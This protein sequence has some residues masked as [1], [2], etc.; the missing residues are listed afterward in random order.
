MRTAVAPRARTFYSCYTTE[1]S[2]VSY[3]SLFRIFAFT[4]E[5]S[6]LLL[7]HLVHVVLEERMGP[8]LPRGVRGLGVAVSKGSVFADDPDEEKYQDKDQDKDQ[9]QD[10][11]KYQDQDQDKDQ[12]QD[13]EK[14]Q[15]QHQD[16]DQD[17]DQEKIKK[18]IKKKSRNRSRQRS[19]QRSRKKSLEKKTQNSRTPRTH[20]HTHLE[21]PSGRGD[22][23]SSTA[24]H[25]WWR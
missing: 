16:K 11:E 21:K 8:D 1:P 3:H 25:H 12:D 24:D 14:Y 13:E 4:T 5:E 23:T 7:S 2:P 22:S 19:R 17:K 15:D 20:T 18:K 6:C 9:D 10:Q